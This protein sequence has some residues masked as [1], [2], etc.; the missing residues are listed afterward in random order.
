ML[1]EN[2]EV[3]RDKCCRRGCKKDKNCFKITY[4]QQY[5]NHLNSTCNTFSPK[6]K[7]YG[8]LNSIS[9]C[10]GYRCWYRCRGCC[11]CRARTKSL[12]GNHPAKSEAELLEIPFFKKKRVCHF[13]L[14]PIIC[15]LKKRSVSC[16]VVRIYDLP[17]KK[18]NIKNLQPGVVSNSG[19]ATFG[20]RFLDLI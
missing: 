8:K 7:L 19:K 3:V 6:K 15:S 11:R 13:L 18:K 20:G 4:H 14:K 9:P 10:L 2:W 17:Q 5:P 12:K 16:W 1:L